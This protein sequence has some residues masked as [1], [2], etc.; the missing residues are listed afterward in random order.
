MKFPSLVILSGIFL[1]GSASPARSAIVS[2]SLTWG[3]DPLETMLDAAGTFMALS[4]SVFRFELGT[5]AT[6]YVAGSDAGTPIAD[7]S[8]LSVADLAN[9]WKPLDIANTGN[10]GWVPATGNFQRGAGGAVNLQE[11]PPDPSI[12]GASN[13]TGNW[14]ATGEKLYV[15]AHNGSD[16]DPGSATEWALFTTNQILPEFEEHGV[17]GG[18]DIDPA[19]TQEVLFGSADG[20]GI[21]TELLP[22]PE[23]A[24]GTL[25]VLA[26]LLLGCRRSRC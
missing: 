18:I 22:A 4:P 9:A 8:A 26:G 5:F 25:L 20:N 23:P 7:P 15:F 10:G 1:L 3:N 19:N 24:T 11:Q 14:F 17:L 6:G 13:I 12:V 16:F 21:Q 2:L